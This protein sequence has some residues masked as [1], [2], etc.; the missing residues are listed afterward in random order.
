[1]GNKAISDALTRALI[2]PHDADLIRQFIAE[3]RSC[4]NISNGRANK[5]IYTLLSW[6][7]FI[8]PFEDNQI[9]DIYTGIA[10]LKEGQSQRGRAFKQ[11]TLSDHVA[12]LKQVYRWLIDNGHSAILEKK[13]NG[14]QTPSKDTMTKVAADLLTPE[15]I[16]AMIK[17]CSRLEDRALIMTLYE[18]GFRIGEICSL[19]WGDLAFDQ[20]G[21]IVN[22]N[23]KTDKPRYVRLI[24]AKDLLAQ[25]RASYHFQPPE[26]KALLFLNEKG[27]QL[28]H[29]TISKRLKTLAVKAG[30]TKPVCCHLFRHSRITHMLR[31][32][33]PES[34]VKM[35]GWGSVSTNMLRTYGHLG[36]EDID[37]ALFKA[38]GIPS[39]KD[40]SRQQTIHPRQCPH[41]AYVNG[42]VSNYC[43]VCGRPLSDDATNQMESA[44][45]QL[46]AYIQTPAGIAATIRALQQLQIKT[47]GEHQQN[48]METVGSTPQRLQ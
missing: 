16:T 15:E 33:V 44:E 23:F 6:R 18:G 40:I 48:T 20:Y 11:N 3:L 47:A 25:W 19:T 41:C 24:M 45:A 31:E 34:V 5:L 10:A 29:A 21:V 2:T 46:N 13:I 32:H 28:E 12:V 35:I 38:Y 36:G 17:A 8:G 7:R 30:I 37:D 1:M 4:K 39:K 43:T 42:P 14:I 22:I 9:T 27:K 26:G